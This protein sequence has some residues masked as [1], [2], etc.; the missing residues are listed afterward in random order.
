MIIFPVYIRKATF[1]QVIYIYHL[2][3]KTPYLDTSHAAMV[4]VTIVRLSDKSSSHIIKLTN[5]AHI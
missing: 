2:L 4:T 5:Q 3:K 1:Q